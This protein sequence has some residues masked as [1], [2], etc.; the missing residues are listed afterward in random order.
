MSDDANFTLRLINEVTRPAKQ[1]TASLRDVRRAMG[2]LGGS[3]K[4]ASGTGKQ[5]GNMLSGL[6]G[7]ASGAA[8][9]GLAAVGIAAGAAALGIGI[10]GVNFA[11]AAIQA[12]SFAQRSTM[13]LELLTGSGT[14]AAREFDLVR[15]EAAAL[16]LDVQGTVK[17]FQK[18]L[19][20]QFEVGKAKE[21]IRMGSDLQAIGASTEEV[22]R[23]MLAITQIKS[24]GRLQ[25]EE[26]LQLQEAGISAELVYKALGERL[27]K[28]GDELR[29]MQMKGEIGADVGLAAIMEAVGKKTGAKKAGDAGKK[30]ATGTLEGM[31]NVLRGNVANVFVDIGQ[32]IEPTLVALGAR[33]PKL[34][35]N[36]M[37][38]PAVAGLGRFLL[39]EFEYFGLWV[40][41]NWTEIEAT[42][43]SGVEMVAASIRGAVEVVRFFT[44]HWSE[45]CNIMLGTAVVMGILTAGGFLL[46]A[47]FLLV[48]G[49]VAA[50]AGAFAYS[51]G[52]IV[53]NWSGFVSDLAYIWNELITWIS[54][55]PARFFQFGVDLIMGLANGVRSAASAAIEAVTGVV[56]NMANAVTSFAGIQSPSTLFA[57]FGG[58]MGA[59]LAVGIE[60]AVPRVTGASTGLAGAAVAPVASA[61]GA[62]GR[63]SSGLGEVHLHV[64]SPPG[65]TR[66]DGE[67]FG[68]G[69]API[70]RREL[71]SLLE[72]EALGGAY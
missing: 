43:I 5:F 13:A 56:G 69:L 40:D 8:V 53:N 65:A 17:T 59:G 41:A 66:E 15:H 49:A 63:A 62:G 2:D 20:A 11:E 22:S 51:I 23:A 64:T 26:M 27:G 72:G 4:M 47:P 3:T 55:L 45:L 60:G 54:G 71:L 39:S 9:A 37:A 25:A 21:L 6:G 57:E 36:I 70:I 31:A 61:A 48:I 24:K 7:V 32:A 18:L 67:R 19:A 14:V 42:I 35:E 52:Y 50:L 16:G 1:A 28:T 34:F 10:L 58:Y 44:D 38:N 12:A 46:L 33:V 30:F 29:K 68:E